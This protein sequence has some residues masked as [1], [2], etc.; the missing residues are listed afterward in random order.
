M[1]TKT[2]HQLVSFNAPPLEVY[3]LLMDAAKHS[4]LT[5]SE[6]LMSTK[7]KGDFEVFDGYCRGYNIELEPG[8]KIVQ[9]WHFNE[10]GWPV[11]H[12]SI[13][14]FL[15]DSIEHGTQLEFTQTDVPSE[16]VDAL[17][18][19]W[20]GFYWEPMAEMLESEEE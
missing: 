18:Q 4:E 14:T 5:G 6:V 7:I 12:F 9:A 20:I 1:E 2:I 10:D 15:F 13:C 19:G 11:D 8:K 3:E 16:F 17:T